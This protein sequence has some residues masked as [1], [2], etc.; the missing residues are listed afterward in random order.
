MEIELLP[1][2]RPELR[3][4]VLA[5]QS[6]VAVCRGDYIAS[7][8]L[9]AEAELDADLVETRVLAAA[10]KAAAELANRGED[11]VSALDSLA[12]VVSETGNYDSAVCAFRAVPGLAQTATHHPRLREILETIARRARDASLAAVAGIASAAR[13][14]APASDL[15]QRELEVLALVAQGLTNPQIASQLFISDKTV[16]THLQNIYEKLGVRSRTEAVVRAKDAGLL[17]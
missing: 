15:S 4:E 13:L 3:G 1:E 14:P 7:R 2:L 9:C 11:L 6:L 16:K 10:S 12:D 5:T 8:E 17:G